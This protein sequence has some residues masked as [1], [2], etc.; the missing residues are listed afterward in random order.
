MKVVFCIPTYTKPFQVCLDSVKASIP[1]IT[2]A[3]W[4]EAM[5]F[6]VGCPYISNA[7][8][9]M[10]RKALD[11]GADVIVYIDHDLSWAPGDLLKLIETPG[12][13]VAGTYRFKCDEVRYMGSL[14]EDAD[15][16]P[17]VRESDGAIKA[18]SV[19]AGFLKVTKFAIQKM[20][21]RYPELVYG[22]PDHPSFDL[23]GH[24]VIDH[25]WYGE[26]MAFSKR[27]IEMGE[28]IIVVPNLSLDHH[29]ADKA[30][31]GN[32]HE[33]L[34]RQPGGAKEIEI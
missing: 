30:Y 22:D 32:Y 28:N 25:V 4:D 27:W 6:E 16:M 31:P 9:T 11:A 14:I 34:Q 5:V 17:I 20:M 10:T 1:L 24:G 3:G 23:F 13:V 15:D 18:H 29:S 12:Q 2:A 19:P 21:R 26:D 8:A 7:R 33:F